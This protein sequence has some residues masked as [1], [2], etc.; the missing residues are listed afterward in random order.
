MLIHFITYFSTWCLVYLTYTCSG[1]G[2]YKEEQQHQ[3]TL[4]TTTPSTLNRSF[5]SSTVKCQA[6][7]HEQWERKC[8][9]PTL[10][11][12]HHHHG[13][14]FGNKNS[15]YDV[16]LLINFACWIWELLS[17]I[18]HFTHPLTLASHKCSYM[19]KSPHSVGKDPN[20]CWLHL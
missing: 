1:C 14:C 19:I 18:S 10:I 15:N 11:N 4:H 2:W 20:Y 5:A 17:L 13:N 9:W 7:C 6:T 12:A 3:Q 16:N 8:C